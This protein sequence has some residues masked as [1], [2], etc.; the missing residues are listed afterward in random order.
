MSTLGDAAKVRDSNLFRAES[1]TFAN[2]DLEESDDLAALL[3]KR[4]GL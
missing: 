1:H 3:G 4:Y 2:F